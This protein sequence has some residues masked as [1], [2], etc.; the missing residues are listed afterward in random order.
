MENTAEAV[1]A[2]LDARWNVNGSLSFPLNVSDKDRAGNV[3]ASYTVLHETK[4]S[5]FLGLMTS[6]LLQWVSRTWSSSQPRTQ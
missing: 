3:M 1:V 6:W 5:Y 2:T 4:N